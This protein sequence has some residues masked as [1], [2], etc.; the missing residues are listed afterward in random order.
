MPNLQNRLNQ[1]WLWPLIWDISKDEFG[2]YSPGHMSKGNRHHP[3][4]ELAKECGY[5]IH[6]YYVIAGPSVLQLMESTGFVY[7]EEWVRIEKTVLNGKTLEP[8]DTVRFLTPGDDKRVLQLQKQ[9][10]QAACKQMLHIMR[11]ERIGHSSE[12]ELKHFRELE[13]YGFDGSPIREMQDSLNIAKRDDVRKMSAL[14][15]YHLSGQ[16][17]G[18]GIGEAAAVSLVERFG[19][20]ESLLRNFQQ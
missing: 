5:D 1:S 20:H 6:G 8:D 2:P 16:T 15:S 12:V 9:L 11:T 14:L 10:R 3:D 7:P 17:N 18:A 13:L 4:S 19:L